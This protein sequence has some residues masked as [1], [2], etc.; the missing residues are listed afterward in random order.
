MKKLFEDKKDEFQEMIEL[1]LK[2]KAAYYE[3]KEIMSDA[4]FDE[5]ENK[6]KEIE[7]NHAVLSVVGYST[8]RFE[9]SHISSMLSLEK[10]QVNNETEEEFENIYKWCEKTLTNEVFIIQPKY[11]GN[12]LSAQYE[13]GKLVRVLTR[14]DGK[15]GFDVTDKISKIIPNE[16]DFNG[17]FEVRGECLIDIND[18]E[19]ININ[20]DFKNERNFVAGV[21][22]DTKNNKNSDK[23]KFVIFNITNQET[24]KYSLLLKKL[25][26]KGFEISDYWFNDFKD[27][28]SIKEFYY[29]MSEYRKN[30]KYRLDGFVIKVDDTATREK[31]GFNKHHPLSEMAIKF[32]AKK[33]ITKIIDIEWT[34]SSQGELVPTAILEPVFLDGSTVSRAYLANLKN[35]INNNYLPTATIQV[36][37]KGDI[38]PQITKL[39]E[40]SE[41]IDTESLKPKSCPFCNSDL[42]YTEDLTHIYCNNK[43]CPEMMVKKFYKGISILK[44]RNIGPAMVKRLYEAGI[45]NVLELFNKNLTDKFLIEN[46]DFKDGREIER[47]FESINSVRNIDYSDLLRIE[48]INGL[49]ETISKM[50]T[51]YYLDAQ[52]NFS[53]LEKNII[54]DLIENKEKYFIDLPKQWTDTTNINITYPN[55]DN[56]EE[57]IKVI[58]TG[59]PKEAGYPTKKFFLDRFTNFEET[60][61]FSEAKYLITDDVNSTSSKMTKAIKNGLEIKTYDEF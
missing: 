46:G 40:E 8:K 61:S 32:P 19:E 14:G 21:L 50:I 33:G 44:L 59:S 20:N 25:E 30:S 10:I 51:K 57:K 13:N 15:K 54:D 23:L 56:E 7:P 34:M 39:I 55:F 28:S 11:D 45:K 49:G 6:I 4:D 31:L 43:E 18:F 22:S 47:L 37:K 52:Y 9:Y 3:G 2:A 41:N 42:T 16:V 38:I 27:S 60:K 17:N 58:L 36:E 53:G 1:Y 5:L 48:Q 26:S 24:E 12:S 29:K 35:A